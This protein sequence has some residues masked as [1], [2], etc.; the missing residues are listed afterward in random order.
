MLT[1]TGTCLDYLHTDERAIIMLLPLVL[2][3]SCA[4]T[5]TTRVRL[6]FKAILAV[7]DQ[8]SDIPAHVLVIGVLVEL[9]L[10]L[11]VSAL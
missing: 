11:L 10:W 3:R 9:E 4:R 7:L 5:I 8:A 6:V 1:I 2:D